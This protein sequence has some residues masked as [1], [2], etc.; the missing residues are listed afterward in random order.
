[1][2]FLEPVLSALNRR[3]VR[4]VVVGGVAV[5][6]HGHPR[7]TAD[8]DLALDLTSDH[9]A[10]AI[11]ALVELGLTPILPVPAGD[12]ADPAVRRKWVEERNLRVFTLYDVGNPLH[13]VDLFAENPIPFDQLWDRGVEVSLTSTTIRIASIDDLISMKQLAGRQKDLADIAALEAIRADGSGP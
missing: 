5:V 12:F 1:M 2:L 7:L 6:L 10:R 3:G 8:L 13:Q 4:Y 11:E 9:A